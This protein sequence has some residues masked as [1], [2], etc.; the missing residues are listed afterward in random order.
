MQC[1]VLTRRVVTLGLGLG[2][3]ATAMAQSAYPSKPIRV[4][5]PYAAGGVV[6]VQT[7][8]LTISM[9]KELGKEINMQEVESKIKNH[10]EDV[11]GVT[12]K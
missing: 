9:A 10:F 2:L 3:A 4:I 1:N 6:D 5:V 7:R 8:A 11:F 12:L